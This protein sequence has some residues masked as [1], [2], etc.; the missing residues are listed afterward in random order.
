MNDVEI[1]DT[2]P[3]HLRM[4]AQAMDETTVEFA[5]KVGLTPSRALWRSWKQSI[6]CKTAFFNGRIAAIWGLGGLCFSDVAF[7]WLVMTPEIAEYPFKV[8]FAYRRELQK[9]QEMFPVLE[10]Y[11]D[12]RNEKSIRMLELMGFRV[13]K[14]PIRCN[15]TMVYKAVRRA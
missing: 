9:M 1:M 3:E 4:M 15:E 5:F 14:E 12:I 13:D 6:I 2:T 10:E 8:A 7:P 11:V